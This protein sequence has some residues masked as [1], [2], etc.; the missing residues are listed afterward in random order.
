MNKI[1]RCLFVLVVLSIFNSPIFSQSPACANFSGVFISDSLEQNLADYTICN[2]SS[3]YLKS[4]NNPSGV[5]YQWK[6]NGVNI[7]GATSRVFNANSVGLYSLTLTEGTCT[8]TSSGITINPSNYN[9]YFLNSFNPETET[10]MGD[11][12]RLY[13]PRGNDVHYQWKKNNVPISDA[14]D[15]YQ[16][17]ARESGIYSVEVTQN[18]CVFNSTTK[19]LIFGND[20]KPFIQIREFRICEGRSTTLRLRNIGKAYNILWSKN[21]IPIVGQN[22]DSLIVS[23]TGNYKVTVSKGTCVGTTNIVITVDNLNLDQP[24]INKPDIT[25]LNGSTCENNVVKLEA[26]RYNDNGALSWYKNGVPLAGQNG[27]ILMARES[28]YYSYRY[29]GNEFC[30]AQSN[31]YKVLISNNLFVDFLGNDVT[32]IPN[33][34]YIIRYNFQGVVPIILR[35]NGFDYP[36]SNPLFSGFYTA[37]S[38][39]QTYTPEA[40]VNACGVGNTLGSATITTQNCPLSTTV[41]GV[42]PGFA[43]ICYGGSQTLSAQNATGQGTLTY[44]WIKDGV[45]IPNSNSSSITISN[46]QETDQGNY[47]VKVTGGCGT[48]TTFPSFMLGQYNITVLAKLN[49]PAY[50]NNIISLSAISNKGI[51]NSSVSYKWTGPDNFSSTLQNPL[52]NNG[53]TINNGI[54][55]VTAKLFNS[56]FNKG[57]V[58]VNLLPCPT[59]KTISINSGNW[60]TSTTWTCGQIP[61]AAYD[62]IIE[63][64][65]TVTLPNGYQGITKKLDLRGGLKQGVGAS[66]RVNN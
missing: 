43:E 21:D 33:Q 29:Q 8:A 12:I 58:N 66:V 65:H 47:L 56:C 16:Y 35:V 6:K 24:L 40:V 42:T 2:G 45:V 7:S 64:G 49:F 14:P 46:F 30:A 22:T 26:Y 39:T 13:L 41:Q 38:T 32:T 50:Q 59:D 34:A 63:N 10:C 48:K 61:T 28:G 19:T 55:E 4:L 1:Y 44:Q 57:L 15:S 18:T 36:E 5:T 54:Y 3:I 23:Q 53:S 37:N 25:V 9:R 17:D 11:S 60:N 62:A 20:A 31:A 27:K 52:I 51:N